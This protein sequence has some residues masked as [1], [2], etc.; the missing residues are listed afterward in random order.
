M[1]KLWAT[2][3]S[4]NPRP[5]SPADQLTPRPG[6]NGQERANPFDAPGLTPTSTVA[7]SVSAGPV[8]PARSG[9]HQHHLLLS[10]RPADLTPTA[11]I[12][13]PVLSHA[14]SHFAAAIPS[15]SLTLHAPPFNIM[16]P[17]S[18][19]RPRSP[20]T[21]TSSSSPH[22]SRS[23]ASTPPT[24][25]SSHSSHPPAQSAVS[26]GQ[27]HVK[28]LQGR[29]LNVRSVKSRPYIVVEFEQNE[30]ISRDPIAE[31]EKEVRGVA[32]TLSRTS[33]STAL[34]ALGAIQNSRAFDIVKRAKSSAN[35]TPRSSVSSGP[36]ALPTGMN[37]VNGLASGSSS[38]GGF[39]GMSAYNP[40][41]K[42][43]VSL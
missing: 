25:V 22:S 35:S 37:G 23:S 10:T 30:F 5:G 7:A 15:S 2:S 31:S 1:I 14:T 19:I 29:G 17:P 9:F 4:P 8:S 40:V 18:P 24:S 32:T 21:S 41:W 16:Q 28:L 6:A 34:N 36:S 39:G 20:L 3:P 26:R 11:G 27:I 42:H 38:F 33:S 43:Q 13:P 12:S